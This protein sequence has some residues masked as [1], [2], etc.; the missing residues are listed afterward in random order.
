MRGHFVDC[1]AGSP[2]LHRETSLEFVGDPDRALVVER[3][4]AHIFDNLL[5]MV[6][7]NQ[8]RL[9]W[10]VKNPDFDTTADV[11]NVPRDTPTKDFP[12]VQT[13]RFRAPAWLCGLSRKAQRIGLRTGPTHNHPFRFKMG[14]EWVTLTPRV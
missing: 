9:Y 3:G 7:M 14:Q 8:P 6:T 5:G 13:N 12:V 4:I 1:R 2:T 11:V 10:D